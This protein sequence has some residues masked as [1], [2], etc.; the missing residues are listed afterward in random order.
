MEFLDYQQRVI[1]ERNELGIKAEN[2]MKFMDPNE[3]GSKWN[4][5][6]RRD[7]ILME[8]QLEVMKKYYNILNERIGRFVK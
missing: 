7:Q 5:L 4:N 3:K 1:E 2:L 8:D 6:S